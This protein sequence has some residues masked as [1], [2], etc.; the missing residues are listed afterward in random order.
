MGIKNLVTRY[1]KQRFVSEALLKTSLSVLAV[2]P[3]AVL[4]PRRACSSGGEI[5][6]LLFPVLFVECHGSCDINTEQLAQVTA[7]MTLLA[8][9][10][11]YL[12]M[13]Y[14]GCPSP[15]KSE[16]FED[17][18]TDCPVTGWPKSCPVSIIQWLVLLTWG[19]PLVPAADTH[20]QAQVQRERFLGELP[21]CART[22]H[23]DSFFFLPLFFS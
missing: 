23:T 17:R 16:I 19:R 20:P 14:S 21:G 6:Q 2:C 9:V 7:G 13:W 18:K 4:T 12:L 11:A 8:P 5:L 3:A 22:D 1:W 15:G 10:W